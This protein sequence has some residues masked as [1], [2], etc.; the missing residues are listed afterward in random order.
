M[1]SYSLGRRLKSN[2]TVGVALLV[3]VFILFSVYIIVERLENNF[4]KALESKARTLLT[5]VKLYPEGVEFDFA[6]EFMPE[7]ESKINPEYFQIWKEDASVLEKSRSLN[8]DTLP[9]MTLEEQ[10]TLF[11][12]SIIHDDREIRAIYISFLPQIPDPALRTPEMLS[13]QIPMVLAVAV[14]RE[15]LLGII[16]RLYVISFI[17]VAVIISLTYFMT[18][19]LVRYALKPLTELQGKIK[20]IHTGDLTKPLF[21]DNPPHELN[22]VIKQFN[23]FMTRLNESFQREKR[24]SS[25]IAHELRTPITEILT[26]S[27]IAKKWPDDTELNKKFHSDVSSSINQIYRIVNSLQQLA[28]CGAGNIDLIHGIISL[29][30]Y[31][32]MKWKKYYDA[33]I[34]KGLELDLDVSNNE[35]IIISIT[36]FDIIVN[37]LLSNAISYSTPNSKITICSD[38]SDK[39]LSLSIQNEIED[40]EQ[41]DLNSMFDKFWRKSYS[42]SDNKHLGLGLSLVKSYADL[43]GLVIEVRLSGNNLFTVTINNIPIN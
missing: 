7:F 19:A 9:L 29:N 3:S 40:L 23:N 10:E 14:E 15:T 39:Y 30:E 11:L 35:R 33:S 21:I 24:F 28:R 6:D 41:N 32:G 20:N 13:H 2:I 18:S 25:D 1:K 42:R 8:N 22:E 12:N 4:D 26:I 5:L 34:A 36:E 31:M 43:L 27:E 38:T 37:N 17:S 16:N